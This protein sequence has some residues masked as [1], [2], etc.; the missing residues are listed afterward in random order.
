LPVLQKAE[1]THFTSFLQAFRIDQACQLL[2]QGYPVNQ[3]AADSGFFNL[4][5][6]NRIFKAEM[7]CTPTQY[8]KRFERIPA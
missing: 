8:Q 1:R 3:A 4:S 7:G 2:D 6:F 5:H